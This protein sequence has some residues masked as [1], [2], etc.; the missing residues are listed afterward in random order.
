[1][2]GTCDPRAKG[3]L[4]V[5]RG[6]GLAVSQP[7]FTKVRGAKVRI[8]SGFSRDSWYGVKQFSSTSTCSYG[9]INTH[10]YVSNYEILFGLNILMSMTY[11]Y[12]LFVYIT[13]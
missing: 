9:V 1:M 11:I 13:S 7:I 4:A 3:I 12:S 6:L 5:A 10:S 2:V 8:L